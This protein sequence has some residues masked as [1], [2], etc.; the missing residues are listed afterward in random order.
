MKKIINSA[1]C[2]QC[3]EILTS[4]FKHDFQMCSCE[5]Q[6]FCDGGSDY[7]RVGGVDFEKITIYDNKLGEYIPMLENGKNNT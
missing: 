5:N 1:R 7:Q 2:L 6:T 4:K 3:G